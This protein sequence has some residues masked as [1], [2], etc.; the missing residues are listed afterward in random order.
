MKRIRFWKI[1]LVV[2]ILFLLISCSVRN[3]PDL[4]GVEGCLPPCW[5]GIKP[6]ET[7]TDLA[8]QILT[9]LETKGEGK[10]QV[11]ETN[12]EWKNKTG[13]SYYLYTENDK[14]KLVKIYIDGVSLQDVVSQFGNPSSFAV[15]NIRDDGNFNVVLF[16]PDKGVAFVADSVNNL[17]FK[18]AP[19]MPISLVFFTKP[20]NLPEMINKLYGEK[21]STTV[22]EAIQKWKGFGDLKP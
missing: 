21:Y 12:I 18:T 14:I 9:D 22:L 20:G 17:G 3:N 4:T 15:T 8:I 6:G 11:L 2:V 1:I 19:N 7:R 16:Y 10:L 5:S 13:Q